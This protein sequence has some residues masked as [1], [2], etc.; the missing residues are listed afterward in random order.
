L[1]VH[2]WWKLMCHG[3][4]DP[5]ARER[6]EKNALVTSAPPVGGSDS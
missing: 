3:A 4:A 5:A 2:R 1:V 6:R